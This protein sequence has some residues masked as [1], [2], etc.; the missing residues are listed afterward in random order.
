MS[1]AAKLREQT[2]ELRKGMPENGN[3]APPPLSTKA[4][5]LQSEIQTMRLDLNRWFI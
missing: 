3:M 2:A 1:A 4:Q 5:N